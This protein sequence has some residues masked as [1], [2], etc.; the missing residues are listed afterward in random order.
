MSKQPEHLNDSRRIIYDSSR[1]STLQD[2]RRRALEVMGVLD[3]NGIKSFVYGSVARGDVSPTSD[4][5]IIVPEL[6]PSYRIEL[7]VGPGIHR[8]IVQA[9]P[10]SVLKA[11]LHLEN[12]VVIS[13]P[14]FKMWSRELDFYRW[15]GLLS[16]KEL[17]EDLRVLGVDKRLIL[18]EPTEDGHLE[19]GVIGREPQ[20]ARAIGVSIDIAE[21]RVRVL[22][23]RSSIGRTGVFLTRT[24]PEDA[25]FEELATRLRDSIP[26]LRRTIERRGGHL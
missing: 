3:K 16:L 25:T 9:T 2:L 5:D 4:I 23:R 1:W 21:E 15:G 20:V 18:I 17:Y 24:V 22:T 6:V 8:E 10:S 11:H 19:H 26:A 13:F 14:L 12:D 7:A